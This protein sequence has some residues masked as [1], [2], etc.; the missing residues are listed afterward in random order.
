MKVISHCKLFGIKKIEL[1]ALQS[2][3]EARKFYEKHEFVLLSEN[4]LNKAP[5]TE[6]NS[7]SITIGCD[8]QQGSIDSSNNNNS[9]NNKKEYCVLL[10]MARQII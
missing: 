3:E 8:L 10:H 2:M 1:T 7:S 6:I 9:N 5:G 4:A